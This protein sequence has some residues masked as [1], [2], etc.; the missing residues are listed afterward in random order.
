MILSGAVHKF[1]VHC[2]A[3]SFIQMKRVIPMSVKIGDVS[4]CLK[5]I[6]FSAPYEQ[7]VAKAIHDSWKVEVLA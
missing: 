7:E 4:G 3:F 6:P 1:E 5:V 2:A